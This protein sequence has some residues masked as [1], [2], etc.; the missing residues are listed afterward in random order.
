MPIPAMRTNALHATA[1]ASDYIRALH[2]LESDRMMPRHW[3]Q[4]VL[5]HINN[6]EAFEGCIQAA[7]EEAAADQ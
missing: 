5:N 4:A 2:R 3:K 7:I 1:Y 6:V